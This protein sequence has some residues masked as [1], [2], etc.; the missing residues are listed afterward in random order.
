[1]RLRLL[2]AVPLAALALAGCS[3]SNDSTAS[4]TVP[5]AANTTT[6]AQ[7]PTTQSPPHA[8][9]ADVVEQV[10][11]SVVSI[12]VQNAFGGGGQGSGVV[13]D[14]NGTILT[15]NHVVEGAANVSVTFND[16]QHGEMQGTVVG[17]D[18]AHDLAVVKVDATDLTAIHIGRSSEL[19]LGD[20]LIAI[21]FPLGLAGGPTVT[22]GIVSGLNRDI[23]VEQGSE[24]KDLIQT[25]AAINPGNSGGALVDADGNLVGINSAAAQA[26]FAENVGFAI[27]IDEAMPIAQ[28]ILSGGGGQQ[29]AEDRAWMGV[30]VGDAPD[31]GAFIGSIV[32][33]SPAAEAGLQAGDVILKV[34]D[35]DVQTSSDLTDALADHKPGDTVT[36]T[37]RSSGGDERTVDVTL[38]TRP[39]TLN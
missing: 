34:G 38:G 10:L 25:D 37:V 18:P 4:T 26:G 12:T 15:N 23:Q 30:S 5:A 19:R 16:D 14:S 9:R 35:T 24:L 31:G 11:A 33:E 3:G 1:M 22:S 20:D 17:T 13:I 6:T 29:Q 2:A 39:I 32:P 8:D 28:D 27:A 7:T 36:V 21:G